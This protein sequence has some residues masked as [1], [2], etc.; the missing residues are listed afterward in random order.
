MGLRDHAPQP[1]SGSGDK[2]RSENVTIQV[3]EINIQDKSKPSPDDHMIGRLMHDACGITAQFDAENSPLTEVKV[4]LRPAENKTANMR[5]EIF[6]FQS[7]RQGVR[8]KSIKPGLG[9][10]CF[11][12]AYM[13]QKTGMI[14][15]RWPEFYT[16]DINSGDTVVHPAALT[17]VYPEWKD[18][19]RA[20]QR[21]VT[22]YPEAAERV[23]NEAELAAAVKKFSVQEGGFGRPFF[24]MR[25]IEADPSGDVTKAF[26]A[27]A[28]YTVGKKKEGDEYVDRTPE[29][30]LEHF[31]STDRPASLIGEW[32]KDPNLIV[33]IIPGSSFDTG[34]DSLPSS[35]N[36]K[37]G[38]KQDNS[39]YFAVLGEGNQKR[40]GA[41]FATSQY[42]ARDDGSYFRVASL[43]INDGKLFTMEEIVTAATPAEF[44]AEFERRARANM[45]F[46][47]EQYKA[48][49]DNSSEQAAKP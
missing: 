42:K 30:T 31:L 14:S 39:I 6:D 5:A 37:T 49:S 25:M 40:T 17:A 3:M 33:E 43:P 7:P 13:D 19:D 15:A 34:R 46:K 9:M 21:S 38:A 44:V 11:S 23:A 47:M 27:S 29:E 10:V 45:E 18:G 20:S 41:Q 48:S 4:F 12:G 2:G 28:G 8:V 36:G 24:M 35:K 32:K 16:R 22:F 26:A 1:R